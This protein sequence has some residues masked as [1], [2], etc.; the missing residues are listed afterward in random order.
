MTLDDLTAL[1]ELK[2]LKS[3]YFRFLDTKD[4][5][6]WR[7]CFTDDFVARVEWSRTPLP[8]DG[9]APN[10]A[11]TGDDFVRQ[12]SEL[13]AGTITVHHGHMPQLTLTGPDSATGVWAMEDIVEHPGVRLARGYGHYHETYRK[14]AGRWRIATLH[15]TRLRLDQT[16]S[17]AAAAE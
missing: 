14:V 15:L 4:W 6:A 17:Q 9:V 3:R 2:Q 8:S 1:E 13:L 5:A 12:V 11:E 10:L 7:E 16:E